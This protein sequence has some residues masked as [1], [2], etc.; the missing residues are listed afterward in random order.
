MNIDTPTKPPSGGPTKDEILAISL[1]KLNLSPCDIFADL[2]CGTGR[3]SREVAPLVKQ[4]LAVDK[5]AE[6]CKWTEKEAHASGI[7]NMSV[8]ND[9]NRTFLSTIDHLDS[10]FVGGSQ[11]LEEVIDALAK[12]KV[13]SLV[14][15]AVML[16]TANT[17]VSY[18]KKHGMFREII[19]AQISRSYSIGSGIMFKPIDPVF[20]ICGGF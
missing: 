10:A 13:R 2:G 6:A 20:I 18:L 14:I 8:F 19:M 12:L 7:S 9:D 1:F 3:I 4:V 11:G 5:R 17:A 15:N 16:E